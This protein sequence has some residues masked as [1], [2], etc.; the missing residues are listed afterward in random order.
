MGSEQFSQAVRG[1]DGTPVATSA[2]GTI[3]TDNYDRGAGFDGQAGDIALNPAT[4]IQELVITILDA[5]VELE[6][7][8]ASGDVIPLRVAAPAT[9][10]KWEIDSLSI[11]DPKG[12][13]ARVAGGWAGD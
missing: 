7:T 6:I 10:D 5:E 8:T 3:E 11:N 9:F 1:S 2:T 4:L 13:N 12:T